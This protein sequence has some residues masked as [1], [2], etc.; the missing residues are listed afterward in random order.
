[1]YDEEHLRLPTDMADF[2]VLIRFHF[3]FAR[4]ALERT[5]VEE[6]EDALG[7]SPPERLERIQSLRLGLGLIKYRDQREETDQRDNFLELDREL[8]PLIE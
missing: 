6:R 1:M 7:L 8:C 2:W 5:T 4:D 3:D